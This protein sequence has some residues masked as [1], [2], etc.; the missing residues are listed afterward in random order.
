MAT[1]GEGMSLLHLAAVYGSE[2][3]IE[4]TVRSIQSSEAIE[5]SA[6]KDN[7][8]RFPRDFVKLLWKSSW[9]DQAETDAL[10]F[11]SLIKPPEVLIFDS[12]DESSQE[13]NNS[14]ATFFTERNFNCHVVRNPTATLMIK[15]IHSIQKVTGLSGLIVFVICPD[16]EDTLKLA[17]G[18]LPVQAV[19]GAMDEVGS[20]VPKVHCI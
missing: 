13:D 9:L 5:L 15:T 12:T 2:D 11:F 7:K 1:D 10:L 14:I 3:V 8:G 19:M 6:L 4:S 17:D 20:S 16:V 18:H